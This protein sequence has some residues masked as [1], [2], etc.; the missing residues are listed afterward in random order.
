MPM[1]SI[2]KTMM[3]YKTAFWKEKGLCG[4]MTTDRG[5]VVCCM[6]DTKPDGSHPCIMGFV[7]ANHA[8]EMENMAPEQRKDAII[9]HYA[10]VFNDNRFLQV[11]CLLNKINESDIDQEEPLLA[12]FPEHPVEVTIIEHMMPSVSSFLWCTGAVLSGL[13]AWYIPKYIVLKLK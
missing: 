2:I 6:D 5:P 9:H 13:L 3:F 11:L 7:L 8:R 4:E 12:E 1:G 10:T